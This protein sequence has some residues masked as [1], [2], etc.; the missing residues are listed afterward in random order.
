MRPCLN[1]RMAPKGAVLLAALTGANLPDAA[2]G[3]AAQMGIILDGRLV[4]APRVN[5]RISERGQITGDFTQEEVDILA[6]VLKAGALPLKVDPIPQSLTVVPQGKLLRWATWGVWAT[7]GALLAM[8]LAATVRF[9]SRGF[10]ASLTIATTVAMLVAGLVLFRFPIT[11]PMVAA[12]CG[13]VLLFAVCA[14]TVCRPVTT[15]PKLEPLPEDSEPSPNTVVPCSFPVRAWP[16]IAMLAL[17]FIT[18]GLF[19]VLGIGPSRGVGFVASIGAVSGAASLVFC[20]WPLIAMPALAEDLTTEELD[21]VY[22][23]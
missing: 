2:T 14:T 6:A 23:D 10:V 8:C 9:G 16:V 20:G 12:A 17:I 22:E 19:Y 13:F 7:G 18:G 15:Q 11:F 5:G 4:S 21:E 1:F 3:E